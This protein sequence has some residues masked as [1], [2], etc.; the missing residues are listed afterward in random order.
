MNRDTRVL[1]VAEIL[2]GLRSVVGLPPDHRGDLVQAF[3]ADRAALEE[4]HAALGRVIEVADKQR[5]RRSG[6]RRVRR[7]GKRT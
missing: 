5:T 1:E 4:L 7:F 3:G 6:T 2:G